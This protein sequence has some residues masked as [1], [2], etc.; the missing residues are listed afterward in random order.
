MKKF[1]KPIEHIKAETYLTSFLESCRD[2]IIEPHGVF[3]RNYADD[4]ISV[5]NDEF[6][7]KLVLQ[8]SRDGIFHILPESLFFIENKL[9]D[10]GK[11]GDPEAFKQEEERIRLEK[12][13]IKAFFQ[14]F[15]LTYFKL[16]F[17]LEKKLNSLSENR[18]PIIMEE[19][20]SVFDFNGYSKDT[21]K[22]PPA[23]FKGGDDRV[24][25][26]E[27]R[28]SMIRKILP[29]IPIASEIRGNKNLLTDLLHILFYPAEIEMF[30]LKRRNKAGVRK[31]VL[32]INV[33]I[34]KLSAK[35]FR[36]LKKEG[37]EFAKFFYE[38]FLPVDLGYEFKIKDKNEPFG[39]G[40]A[41]TLDYNTYL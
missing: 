1:P 33:Y 17:E 13:K 2:V 31:N 15:D 24:K 38:W 12:E 10:L 39:L 22:H 21:E 4:I 25:G 14:P 9:R 34:E 36:N 5:D 23:P 18:I 20:F 41:M 35:Q 11:K 8:L 28:N 37:D 6:G 26:G 16:K 32:K 40:K 29:V 3:S 27:V 19:L 30:L 7:N